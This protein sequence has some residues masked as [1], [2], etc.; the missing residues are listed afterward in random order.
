MKFNFVPL[1]DLDKVDKDGIVDVIGVVMIVGD[2]DEINSKNTNK[3]YSKRDITIVDSSN[4][5]VRCTVWG[6]TATGWEIPLETVVAF[7]GVKVSDF[8]GRSLSALFTSSITPNPDIDEAHGLKGWFD[9]Q[10]QRD[11]S[12][13]AT[14]NNAMGAATGRSDPIKNI[15]EVREENLGMGEKPDFFLLKAMIVY[16]KR[17]NLSYPA[18][19]KETC[20]KKVN[21]QSDELWYCEKCSE[22][23]AKPV[24]R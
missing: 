10:G 14:H 18:C 23:F 16:I 21:Q 24:H 2:V 5:Q 3:S 8:G 6:K 9:G 13:F 20:S 15:Q 7:K 4:A 1:A 12:S 11:L 19:G 17:E 22:G